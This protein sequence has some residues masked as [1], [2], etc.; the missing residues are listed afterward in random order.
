MDAKPHR[1]SY[2][3]LAFY[4]ITIIAIVFV[5]L[6]FSELRLLGQFF[7]ESNWNVLLGI[8][9]IQL[10][11]YFAQ[12]LNY[13]AVLRIKNLRV[14]VWELF[15]TSFVVQFIS[16]A[17]PTGGVSGQVFFIYYLKKYGLTLTEGIGRAILEVLTLYMTYAVYFAISALLLFR[18]QGFRS[19]PKLV[20]FVYAFMV[21][22]AICAV[23]IILSQKRT[24]DSRL[25]MIFDRIIGYLKRSGILNLP[26]VRTLTSHSDHFVMVQDEFKAT[27]GLHKLKQHGWLL[28]LAC[29]WQGVLLMT[30]VITLYV[31]AISL[32]HPIP[33]AACFIAFTFSKFLSMISI[34]PGAPGVFEGA[35]TLILISFGVDKSVALAATLLTRAFTFWLAMPIGWLL[36]GHYMKKFAA[37]GA[38][39]KP[40]VL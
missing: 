36:Y 17:I 26:G 3:R 7:R 5:Y 35:M 22:L 32:G 37:A 4:I 11:G 23:V 30:S 15:P 8:V 16:Q 24:R 33:F 6:K 29:L 21:F 2:G 12:A 9:G 18:N 13:Q 28:L 34:I 39:D 14:G 40:V 38:N 25:H 1:F 19:E 10:I 20:F 27:L 31:I